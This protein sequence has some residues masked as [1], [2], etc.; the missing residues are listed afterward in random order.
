MEEPRCVVALFQSSGIAEDARNRLKTEGVPG[1]E[2]ALNIL[3]PKGPI[4]PTVTD[5]LE[6]LSVDPL[7][8]GNVR[9][10]FASFIRD[11]ETAL[12]VRAG[13]DEQVEFAADTLRQYA[14]I[15]LDTI[16]LAAE[17][18]LVRALSDAEP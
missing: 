8:W 6:A 17:P 7:V 14:P 13:T 11:G 18:G 5:E 9:E 3:K 15:A 16:P 10:T 1:S 4:P 12:L 2:I